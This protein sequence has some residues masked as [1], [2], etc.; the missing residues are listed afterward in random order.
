MPD[1]VQQAIARPVVNHRGPE[2]RAT[3]AR[4]Q[5]LLK[6]L[7][8]THNPVLLHAST[9]T[10]MMEASLAN[11]VSPGDRVL[12]CAHGQFGD[13]YAAIAAAMGAA[14]D[15]LE[16]AWGT[17]IAPKT[18]ESLLDNA[19]YRAVVV[20]HNESSTAVTTDLAA[21][22]ALLCD[23]P[24]LLIAD[25]VSGLGGLEMRQDAWGVDIVISASQK[26]LM[27]P[28]GLGLAS[29][30][31]KAWDVVD[32]E[33]STRRYYWDF[34]KHRAA[35]EKSETPFTAPVTLIA[36]LCESLEMI[37]EEGVAAV[38]ARHRRLSTMLRDGCTA[39]GLSTFGD[40]A[41][42]SP[43]VVALN[44]PEGIDGSAI[45]RRMYER[46]STVTAGSRNKLAGRVIRIGTMGWISETDI[47]SDLAQLEEVLN[48]VKNAR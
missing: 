3:M 44:V 6:P 10:G 4:V 33:D 19:G 24:T 23:R 22:G 16:F 28:P 14:V 46:Y 18:V 37:H 43:T 42:L 29:L 45:V 12:V 34:R 13:R 5:E 17:P 39:M 7:I 48:E 30:S 1:R 32:R 2:F 8:G 36:G 26:A 38:L 15:T 25:S 9:G 21:L 40:P 41:A 47:R 27:C 11:V 20:V 31:D 35:A